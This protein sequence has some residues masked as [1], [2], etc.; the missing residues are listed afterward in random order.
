M[1]HN[2]KHFNLSVN[3]FKTALLF[4]FIFIN[5]YPFK[6]YGLRISLII[7]LF[8][9]VFSYNFKTF[10][11]FKKGA[12]II[13]FAVLVTLFSIFTFI[14][15]GN[16]GQFILGRNLRIL[17]SSILIV[18]I[19]GKIVYSKEQ[20][21]SV[22]KFVLFVNV[23]IVLIQFVF[24]DSKMIF[25]SLVGY[26][27]KIVPFRSFG[28][29][30]SYDFTGFYCLL[31]VL[32][33]SLINNKK[34]KILNNLALLL[35]IGSC[36]LT[37]R[38]AMAICS[39]L[40]IY[41]IYINRKKIRVI[42]IVIGGFVIAK[43]L[44]KYIYLLILVLV[45]SMP[46][47]GYLFNF[48]IPNSVGIENSYG[49]NSA[50]LLIGKMV[51]MPKSY[52]LLFGYG[53]N[54]EGSDIGYVHLLFLYG[55]IG[56]SIILIF[57]TKIIYKGLKILKRLKNLELFKTYLFFS[58]L[59]FVYNYKL[60]FITASGAYELFIL[61]YLFILFLKQNYTNELQY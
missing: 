44:I 28:M 5:I 46:Q 23:L 8:L 50:S 15:T 52:Y 55:L 47:L 42:H 40:V 18:L 56:T 41:L 13:Y 24:P 53:I 57:Y 10:L 32:V 30:T 4:I 36:F 29:F 19:F 58:I 20:F 33:F 43:V 11:N 61:F 49:I 2:L 39:L 12:I 21:I 6:I 3:S 54:P 48:P 14:T 22:L 37:S 51:F 1:Q 16:I 17:I 25:A 38:L 7:N 59:L 9:V 31:S 27:K 26:E 60:T 34:Y 35:S 45:V